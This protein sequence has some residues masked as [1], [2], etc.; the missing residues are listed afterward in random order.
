MWM[1]L[2]LIKNGKHK[3]FCGNLK[4]KRGRIQEARDRAVRG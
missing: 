4:E 1:E 3:F 2:G